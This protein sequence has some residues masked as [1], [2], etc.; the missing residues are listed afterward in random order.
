MTLGAS[1]TRVLMTLGS[2]LSVP[3]HAL[4]DYPHIHPSLIMQQLKL[5][6]QLELL[7]CKAP[8]PGDEQPRQELNHHAQQPDHQPQTHDQ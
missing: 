1:I 4:V 6:P 8:R 3:Q 2:R 5:Q 7:T